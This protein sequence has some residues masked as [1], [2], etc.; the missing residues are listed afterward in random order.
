MG[1][2]CTLSLE[3]GQALSSGFHWPA[4]HCDIDGGRVSSPRSW[5]I[6]YFYFCSLGTLAFM[7]LPLGIQLAYVRSLPESARLS[8]PWWCQPAIN[9][10]CRLL[11]V[12]LVAPY[13]PAFNIW[14]QQHYKTT[15]KNC[16]SEPSQHAEYLS[17]VARNCGLMSLNF[18]KSDMDKICS[19]TFRSMQ[20][21]QTLKDTKYQ[22]YIQNL[23]GE[24]E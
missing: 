17:I 12:I 22:I 24:T 16:L 13:N 10:I 6:G 21:F 19:K 7:M 23:S 18:S 14:L 15:R 1:D 11:L 8:S 3:S 9:S 20:K 4:E 2:V 5:L